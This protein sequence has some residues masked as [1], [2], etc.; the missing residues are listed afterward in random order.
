MK[1]QEQ[2]YE[3]QTIRRADMDNFKFEIQADL[4]QKMDFLYQ[5]LTARSFQQANYHTNQQA[6]QANQ[7]ANQQTNQQ[8]NQQISQQTYPVQQVPYQPTYL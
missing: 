6:Y 5:R 4:Q 3:E 8:A 2:S 1:K 7:Q